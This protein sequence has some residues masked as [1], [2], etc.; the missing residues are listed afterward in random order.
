VLVQSNI[1]RLLRRSYRGGGM[2][3]MQVRE[4][5]ERGGGDNSKFSLWERKVCDAKKS[6]PVSRSHTLQLGVLVED[7]DGPLALPPSSPPYTTFFASYESQDLPPCTGMRTSSPLSSPP[8]PS[9]QI[10]MFYSV[11]ARG[12]LSR[13]F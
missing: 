3:V 10:G 9:S 6:L 11:C 8:D 4:V 13:G 1:C 5:V 2:V 12:T 7:K